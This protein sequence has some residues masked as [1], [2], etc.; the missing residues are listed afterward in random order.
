VRKL[1]LERYAIFKIPIE[2]LR[3]DEPDYGVDDLMVI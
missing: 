1:L 2:L 3:G